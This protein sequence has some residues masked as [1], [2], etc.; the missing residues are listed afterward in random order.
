[1]TQVI[2]SKNKLTH[3]PLCVLPFGLFLGII[4]GLE[5][6]YIDY[7]LFYKRIINNQ[8]LQQ[9]AGLPHLS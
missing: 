5:Y 6:F 9:A 1:M 3:Y 4:I 7:I 2:Q 8:T